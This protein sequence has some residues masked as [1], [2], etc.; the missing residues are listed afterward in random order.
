MDPYA[1]NP[2]PLTTNKGD[3]L[4]A[5]EATADYDPFLDYVMLS[6]DANDGLLMWIT[7]GINATADYTDLA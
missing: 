2:V 1:R 6:D 5:D 7:V 3:F 4:T